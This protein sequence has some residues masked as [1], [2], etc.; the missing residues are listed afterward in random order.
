MKNQSKSGQVNIY[1]FVF[2]RTLF[3][4]IYINIDTLLSQLFNYYLTWTWW[5]Y[6]ATTKYIYFLKVF[7][8]Y[9]YSKR[10]YIFSK[11]QKKK[12]IS[13]LHK[14]LVASLIWFCEIYFLLFGGNLTKIYTKKNVWKYFLLR[15]NFYINII[16]ITYLHIPWLYTTTYT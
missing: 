2:N 11:W 3:E 13:I 8:F 7:I 14:F 5:C 15:L 6:C 9:K 12:T 1:I 4:N 16:P 10:I